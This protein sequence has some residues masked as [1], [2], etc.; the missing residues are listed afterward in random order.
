[1]LLLTPPPP[2]LHVCVDYMHLFSSVRV[3]SSHL[4]SSA[5]A[6]LRTH[7]ALQA[8]LA[9]S[10]AATEAEVVA[11]VRQAKEH[12]ER[13]AQLQNEQVRARRELE[14]L[15]KEL[16]ALAAQRSELEA[17][18]AASVGSVS[19]ARAKIEAEYKQ[20]RGQHD[21]LLAAHARQKQ[22]YQVMLQARHE[23]SMSLKQASLSADALGKKLDAL[24]IDK[25]KRDRLMDKIAKLEHML[26]VPDDADPATVAAATAA[27]AAAASA[28]ATAASPSGSPTTI[29]APTPACNG[30]LLLKYRY[31]QLEAE[32]NV[33]NVRLNELRLLNHELDEAAR[34][35]ASAL[36]YRLKQLDKDARD[37]N[38]WKSLARAHEHEA[39]ESVQWKARLKQTKQRERILEQELREAA[40]W[41]ARA[42]SVEKEVRALR[43]WK[44]RMD[45]AGIGGDVPA[46]A[47]VVGGGGGGGV[48]GVS[49]S[50]MLLPDRRPS[51]PPAALG[52][53]F[54]SSSSS[55]AGA[56]SSPSFDSS[57]F[58]A[59]LSS[60]Q[61]QK[62]VGAGGGFT[63]LLVGGAVNGGGSSSLHGRAD[64]DDFGFGV[65]SSLSSGVN[66]SF[67]G[68][69]AWGSGFVDGLV[70]DAPLASV[71]SSSSSVSSPAAAVG[72]DV[73]AGGVSAQDELETDPDADFVHNHPAL[74]FLAE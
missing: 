54:A 20:L 12:T 70:S 6:S 46:F 7:S 73:A 65:G 21:D 52:S 5:S 28:A 14:R 35:E 26:G 55:I 40:E 32:H 15:G 37:L 24:K 27:A 38:K 71:A 41:K 36:R 67:G 30:A 53:D 66:S 47:R 4:L 39:K 19:R 18:M 60:Y 17:S 62:P 31:S 61:Q 8:Q 56:S 45:A 23:A 64:S 63:G 2:V 50:M 9:S 74:A 43:Q 44:A 58:A 16:A 72:A 68:A 42:K 57:S 13:A 51:L 59:S 10:V 22:S 11:L 69:S 1:M 29:S 48:D 49:S 3:R 34:E 33:L 25:I